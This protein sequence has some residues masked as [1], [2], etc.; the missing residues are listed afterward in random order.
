MKFINRYREFLLLFFIGILVYLWVVLSDDIPFSIVCPF[1]AVTGLP[2]PGCGGTRAA[3]AL[4][5]GDLLLALYINPLSCLLVLFY[6]VLLVWSIYDGYCARNSLFLSLAKPW[7]NSYF[8]ITI[9][10]IILNGIWNIC[11]EL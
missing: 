11:K 2:C 9:V 7:K 10:V 4:L 6:I 1:K 5:Q 8:W 3:Q